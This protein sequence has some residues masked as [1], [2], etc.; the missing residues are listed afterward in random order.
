MPLNEREPNN[1]LSNEELLVGIM[2]TLDA[3]LVG[4]IGNYNNRRIQRT[5][6]PDYIV[7]T[8]KAPDTP[9]YETAI[10]S[11]KY[12]KGSWIIVQEYNTETEAR[13]GHERWLTCMELQPIQLYDVHVARPS[14]RT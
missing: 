7:S 12:N 5:E 13:E 2:R 3:F 10:M 4:G 14:R 1:P 11:P 8:V 9:Y 6:C